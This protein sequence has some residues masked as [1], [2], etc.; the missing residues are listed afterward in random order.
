MEKHADY[1]LLISTCPN[2]DVANQI[3]RALVESHLV[4]CVNIV[5]TIHSVFE[6]KNEVTT[7]TEVLLL[8]KTRLQHYA[9][10]EQLVLQWHPYQVPELIGI[11]IET[12]LPKYLAWIDEVVG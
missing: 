4:A 1:Q 2:L 8:M 3:A 10:I 11:P 9:T 5:P 12:G 6:W 7:E